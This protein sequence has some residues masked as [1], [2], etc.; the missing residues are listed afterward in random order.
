MNS[1]FEET[2]NAKTPV[3]LTPLQDPIVVKK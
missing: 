3:F 1:E 2:M